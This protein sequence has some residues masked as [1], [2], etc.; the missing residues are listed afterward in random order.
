MLAFATLKLIKQVVSNGVSPESTRLVSAALLKNDSA[1]SAVVFDTSY[2]ACD[3][4]VLPLQERSNTAFCSVYADIS[5]PYC[6]I[7]PSEALSLTGFTVWLM[8]LLSFSYQFKI[9]YVGSF[10][11]CLDCKF[12]IT[13]FWW[14]ASCIC[15]WSVTVTNQLQIMQLELSSLMNSSSVEFMI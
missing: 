9:K 5:S 12:K 10:D 13:G 4:A 3:S 2:T 11:W 6:S 8:I 7:M 14:H 1:C 15:Y